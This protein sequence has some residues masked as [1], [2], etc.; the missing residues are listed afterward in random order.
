MA[1]DPRRVVIARVLAVV[2]D[3]VQLGLF[4]LFFEGALSAVNDVLDVCVGVAMVFLVGWHWA[5]VPA[6]LT[7]LVPYL[8]LVPTWTAA[9]LIATRQASTG[10]GAPPAAPAGPG[11]AVAK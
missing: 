8:D 9:V 7:E 11:P 1:L 10:G 4:P 2:A 5:F 6:F 3:A